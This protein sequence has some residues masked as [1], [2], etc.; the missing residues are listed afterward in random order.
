MPVGIAP[1]AGV[2]LGG[3]IALFGVL[4]GVPAE[5]FTGLDAERNLP[6]FFSAALLV[7]AALL[8]LLHA[9]NVQRLAPAALAALLAFLAVD[10]LRTVHETL[11]RRTGVDWQ[12][13][14]APL[15]LGGAVVG[16]LTLGGLHLG[17]RLL[18]VLAGVTWTVAQALEGLQ[19][20]GDTLVHA[21]RILP[22]EL[23]EMAGSALI[24]VALLRNAEENGFAWQS[25]RW[26]LR[27]RRR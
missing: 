22:E 12:L 7:A 10:E 16:T 21:W 13:L 27:L 15:L 24:V 11:E 3:A 2:A 5:P 25:S 26:A 23:L 17:P 19:W 4:Y 6:A 20:D 1:L 8:M 18:L 14:Y 9:R